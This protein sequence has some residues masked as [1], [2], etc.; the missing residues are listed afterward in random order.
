MAFV[1]SFHGEDG[2]ANGGCA[3]G[4]GSERTAQSIA[5]AMAS[6]DNRFINPLY[7]RPNARTSPHWARCDHSFP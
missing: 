5:A 2:G 4:A 1:S 3:A 7:S 6:K